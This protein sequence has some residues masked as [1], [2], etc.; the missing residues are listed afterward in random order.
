[1]LP[2][3]SFLQRSLFAKQR[4]VKFGRPPKLKPREKAE[5]AERHAQGQTCAQIAL[6]FGV[7]ERTTMRALG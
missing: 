3:F 2:A 1:M 5:I 7:S 4:V 6:M